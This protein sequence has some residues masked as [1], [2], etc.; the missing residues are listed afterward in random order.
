MEINKIYESWN[1]NQSNS[2]VKNKLDYNKIVDKILFLSKTY[3]VS[4][5]DEAASVKDIHT[6]KEHKK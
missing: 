4:G 2:L 1:P 5:G 6:L 3:N